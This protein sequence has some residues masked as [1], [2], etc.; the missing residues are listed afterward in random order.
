MA[1]RLAP[2]LKGGDLVVLEGP[3]GSGKTFFTR[4]LAR[5][6]GLPSSERVTSPTFTL[7]QELDTAPPVLHADVFRLTGS[8]DVAELGLRASRDRGAI[9]V[10]EWGRPYMDLLGGDAVLIE[11]GDEPRRA[12]IT[13]TGPRAAKVVASL[14]E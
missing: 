9:L 4:A 5:A 2:S 8:D 10:V 12:R 1:K 14:I 11:L 7:V 3:L 13:A 6:L